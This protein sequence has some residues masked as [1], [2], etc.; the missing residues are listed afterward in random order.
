MLN[1]IL[2]LTCTFLM[3]MSIVFIVI[4]LR[5]RFDKS[6]L[7][8]GI[9]NLLLAFFC[10][11]DIWIQPGT[12][13]MDWT[14]IQHVIAA[15]FPAFI[16]WYLMALLNRRSS[17]VIKSMFFIGFCFSLLFFNNSMFRFTEKELKVL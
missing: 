17:S 13:R 16:L 4:E 6:F 11:I 12:I 9:T 2:E 3:A 10:A 14:R 5:A 7:I 1:F 15:F 8:F